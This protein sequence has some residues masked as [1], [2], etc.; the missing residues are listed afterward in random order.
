VENRILA[1]VRDPERMLVSTEAT[2]AA[3]LTMTQAAL[4]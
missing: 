4:S 1:A 2:P 3:L